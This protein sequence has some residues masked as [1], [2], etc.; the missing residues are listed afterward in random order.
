[1][2]VPV[3]IVLASK[4]ELAVK[5]INPVFQSAI[6]VGFNRL[7]SVTIFSH[8]SLPKFDSVSL[9]LSPVEMVRNTLAHHRTLNQKPLEKERINTR[10]EK[11][12]RSGIQTEL[13]GRATEPSSLTITSG[14]GQVFSRAGDQA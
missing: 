7:R 6:S 9:D 4:K 2:W 12:C 3:E 11:D 13:P 10:D 14:S 1:M 5:A 8:F